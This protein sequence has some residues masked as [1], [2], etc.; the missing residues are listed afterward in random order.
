MEPKS[1]SVNQNPNPLS[2]YL[3]TVARNLRSSPQR[4]VARW[5]ERR[6]WC[7]FYLEDQA[8]TCNGQGV[9]WLSLYEQGRKQTK[10]RE[11]I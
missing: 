2:A 7:V 6:G 3:L 4:V 9:C 10:T 8:R 1:A 5:L 11:L